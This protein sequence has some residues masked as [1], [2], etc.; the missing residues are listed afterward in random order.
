MKKQNILKQLLN[1]HHYLDWNNRPNPFKVYAN[2]SSIALPSDFPKPSMNAIDAI[3]GDIYGKE[4][5]PGLKLHADEVIESKHHYRPMRLT[6]VSSILFFTCGVTRQLKF[7]SG[8]FYMRAASATGALYPIEV[9]LY[10]TIFQTINW[11]LEYI[12][13][14]PGI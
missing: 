11:M 4:K 3:N 2:L 5:S 6:D 10:A 8:T 7:D 13:L 9:H 12:I 1:S 14:I